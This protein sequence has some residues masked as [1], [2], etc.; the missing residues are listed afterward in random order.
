MTMKSMRN[1]KGQFIKGSTGRFPSLETRKKLSLAAKRTMNGF[2]KGHKI[3]LGHHHT[4]E[5]KA[6]I[7]VAHRGGKSYNWK[8]DD[9]KYMGLHNWLRRNLGNPKQCEQCGLTGRVV[10]GRWNIDWAKVEGKPYERK[11][12]NFLGLCRRCHKIYDSVSPIPA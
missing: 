1:K 7:A 9:V 4:D 3:F 5:N 6:K 12:E 11:R 2:K 8:G 10:K